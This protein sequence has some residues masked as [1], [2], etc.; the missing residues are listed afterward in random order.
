MLGISLLV[1]DEIGGRGKVSG[2]AGPSTA[3]GIL[4][5]SGDSSEL[6]RRD[7]LGGLGR[8][9]LLDDVAL[10]R[11]LENHCGEGW[12]KL[13]GWLGEEGSSWVLGTRKGRHGRPL[14]PNPRITGGWHEG[15][16]VDLHC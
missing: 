14:Y 8:R 3:G 6:D 2:D 12:I 10:V 9:P 15:Q 1:G 7:V 13:C 4:E 11:R 5:G 16:L